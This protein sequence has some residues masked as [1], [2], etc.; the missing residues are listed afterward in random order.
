MAR[1]IIVGG[2]QGRRLRKEAEKRESYNRKQNTKIERKMVIIA[3]EDGKSSRLYFKAIFADLKKSLATASKFLIVD[4]QHTDP[5]GVLQDLCNYEGYEEYDHKW[6][7]IDRDEKR[8]RKGNT[9]GWSS[10]QFSQALADAAKKEIRVAYANP[11]FEIWVLLHFQ[12]WDKKFDRYVLERYLKRYYQYE[13]STLF[14]PMFD[15]KLQKTAIKNATELMRWR[16]GQGLNLATDNP[17]T[18]IHELVE[19]LNG[20]KS[21]P[22]EPLKDANNGL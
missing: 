22:K 10:E 14:L 21:K 20:F 4:H 2:A 18:T 1:R 13:K 8:I 12:Y 16:E 6:I 17:S 5:C 9:G 11:C 15:S 3:C 7:V 19:L